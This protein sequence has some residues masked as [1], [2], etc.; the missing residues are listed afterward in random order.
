MTHNQVPKLKLPR[1]SYGP[2]CNKILY[3]FMLYHEIIGDVPNVSDSMDEALSKI[4][5]IMI[6]SLDKDT[7]LSIIEDAQ[8]YISEIPPAAR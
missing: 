3:D 7:Q 5:N 1:L 4:F 6:K 2:L 8:K